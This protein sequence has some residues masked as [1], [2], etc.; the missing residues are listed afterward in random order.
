MIPN[1]T[2]DLL[3]FHKLLRLISEFANSDASRLSVLDI[4]SAQ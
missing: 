2:L 4:Q 1:N 3:E